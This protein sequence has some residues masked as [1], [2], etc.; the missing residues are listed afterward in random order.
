MASA[1]GTETTSHL[2][3]TSGSGRWQFWGAAISRFRANPLNGGGAGSWQSWGLE[4][5][6]LPLPSEFAHFALP[7]VARRAG[8][9]GLVLVLGAVLVAAVVRSGP[10]FLLQSGEIA[11]AAACG[12][13]FFLAAAYDWV[14]Q[15]AGIAVVRVGMLGFALGALP[16]ERATAWG[17]FGVVRPI[18]ALAGG[19]SHSA[20][21]RM[22]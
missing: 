11:A 7:R 16:S 14:W 4:H 3:Q 17:R 10:H 13:A 12:M 1:E 21:W 8:N 9:L 22:P 19:G 5:G 15:L 20:V 2:L 6:S 18:I